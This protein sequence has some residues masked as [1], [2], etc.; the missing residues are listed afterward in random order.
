[1]FESFIKDLEKRKQDH[2]YR[3]LVKPSGED[4]VSND[5][6]NLSCHPKVQQALIE[7]LQQGV[8]LSGKASRLLAGTTS[9]HE[10]V[11]EELQEWLSR[12]GVLSFSSGYLANVGV[13]SLLCKDKVVFSDQLNHA[14]LIDG[15]SLSKSPCRIYPHNDLNVLESLLK[16]EKGQKVIVTESLFSME[17]DFAPL[18]EISQLALQHGALLIVDEAHATGIFGNNFSGCVSDLKEK[19]HVVSLHTCGKALGGFGAFVGSSALLKDYLINCC[20]SFIYTTA[21]PPLFL[22]QLKTILKILKEEPFR[23]LN[24]RKQALAFRSSLSPHFSLEKTESPILPLRVSSSQEALQFEK[25]LRA[26]GFDVKAIR[27]PTVP[28]GREGV[29]L[30]LKYNHSSKLL[31]SLLK[32]LLEK[33]S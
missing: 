31:D 19:D 29:R 2:L 9:W 33:E 3:T 7:A 21:L 23:P 24:L 12:E 15:I 17:G 32:A 5:Y 14:S 6:L 11:E 30:V 8:S 25:K 13:L 4:F 1:M 27:R 16:K 22:F 20:R 10:E 28:E 18:N 26:K